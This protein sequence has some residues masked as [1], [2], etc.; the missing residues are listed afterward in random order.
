MIRL[1]I[2]PHISRA[3]YVLKEP[4]SLKDKIASGR[5]AVGRETLERLI[6]DKS[7]AS[8]A[9]STKEDQI[10]VER[11][12]REFDSFKEFDRKLQ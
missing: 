7:G 2:Y 3:A 8:T 11:N 9:Y 12:K 6:S 5:A 4:Q 10:N 1:Y